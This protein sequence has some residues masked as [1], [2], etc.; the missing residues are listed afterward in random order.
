MRRSVICPG[1]GLDHP[2]GGGGNTPGGVRRSRCESWLRAGGDAAAR[3]A[4]SPARPTAHRGRGRGTRVTAHG[5][6]LKR[7]AEWAL[8]ATRS[9]RRPRGTADSHRDASL[10]RTSQTT[11]LLTRRVRAQRVGAGGGERASHL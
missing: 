9:R 3:A 6:A 11:P 8:G 7:S 4:A 2:A 1:P 5:R 10:A